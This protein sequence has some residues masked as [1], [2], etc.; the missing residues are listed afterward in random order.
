LLAKI[1]KKI[2]KKEKNAIVLKKMF[3]F[4]SRN[5]KSIKI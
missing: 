5:T 3:I 2:D 4:A 1:K